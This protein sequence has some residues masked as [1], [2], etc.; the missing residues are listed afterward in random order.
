VRA[1]GVGG[2]FPRGNEVEIQ[3]LAVQIVIPATASNNDIVS[4][5]QPPSF[6]DSCKGVA[7]RT[8]SRKIGNR[9]GGSKKG[10][11]GARGSLR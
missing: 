7:I 2:R 4:R 8:V 9:G 10:D 1:G 3:G 5:A 6:G 11:I